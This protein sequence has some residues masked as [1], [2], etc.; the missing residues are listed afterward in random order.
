MDRERTGRET[1]KQ[2]KTGRWRWHE[3]ENKRERRK[4]RGMKWTGKSGAERQT[5]T[6]TRRERQE[7][8][9]LK[10]GDKNKRERELCLR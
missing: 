9:R 2:R 6:D 1:D 8:W 5:A 3:K 4:K 10:A 7:I